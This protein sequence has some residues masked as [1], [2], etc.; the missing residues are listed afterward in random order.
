M[1]SVLRELERAGAA[2]RREEPLSAHTSFRIGGPVRAMVFPRGEAELIQAARI[3]RDAEIVPLL[4]GNGSNLLAADGPIDK[5][6]IKTHA[7]MADV[8]RT[9]GET[10]YAAAG[11]LLSRAAVFARAQGLGGLAFAHG[12]PGT[13][14]G[15]VVMN[16]GAYGGDGT[17]LAAEL[18]FYVVVNMARDNGFFGDARP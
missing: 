4:V 9:E 1:E 3:L 16:A 10:I 14:G 8:R 18:F 15:A 13:L 6:A 11:A 5:I 7:G 12:I 2:L 17:H